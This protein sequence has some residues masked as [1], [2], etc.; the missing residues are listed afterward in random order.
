M[1]GSGF[2]SNDSVVEAEL[3][4]NFPR[5]SML[6]STIALLFSDEMDFFIHDKLGVLLVRDM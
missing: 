6:F 1:P 5:S 4:I 2:C 3:G